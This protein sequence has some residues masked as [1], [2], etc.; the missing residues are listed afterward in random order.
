MEAMYLVLVYTLSPSP[1]AF[2]KYIPGRMPEYMPETNARQFFKPNASICIYKYIMMS[3]KVS[4]CSST[5]F[6]Q[7]R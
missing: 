6:D 7:P 4:D 2:W 5:T 1:D 3:R